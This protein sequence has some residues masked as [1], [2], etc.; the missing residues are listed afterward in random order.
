[1][2]ELYPIIQYNWWKATISKIS[3]LSNIA[4]AQYLEQARS[5]ADFETREMLLIYA[6]LDSTNIDYICENK[7]YRQHHVIKLHDFRREQ[8]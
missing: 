3:Y 6:V 8:Y 1:M 5:L 2:S 7:I 4:H